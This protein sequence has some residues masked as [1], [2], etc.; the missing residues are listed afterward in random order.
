M[1]KH[2]SLVLNVIIIIAVSILYFLHFSGSGEETVDQEMGSRD[3]NANLSIAY[4]NSDSLLKNYEYFQEMAEQLDEKRQ[5]LEAE[6]KNRAQGLQNEIS[7]FQRTAQNMTISQAKA[8][9]EDLM[10]KQQNLMQYQDQL[11]QQL[12][13]EEAKINEELYERVSAYLKDYG[14]NNDLELVLTYQKGSGVLYANDSL[15]I[16]ESIVDGLNQAYSGADQAVP[17]PS[18]ADTVK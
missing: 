13:Q 17:S 8:V 11:T 4:I 18:E 1:T 15:N 16:T 12:M 2:I 5:K 9:E 3:L 10:K 7:N 6:Y 14:K